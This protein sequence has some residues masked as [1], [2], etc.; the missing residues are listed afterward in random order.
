[1]AGAD[2]T[3]CRDYTCPGFNECGEAADRHRALT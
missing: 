2:V 1:M 3:F